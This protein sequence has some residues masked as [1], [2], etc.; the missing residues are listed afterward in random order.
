VT[1]KKAEIK[2]RLQQKWRYAGK[3]S[4]IDCSKQSEKNDYCVH[5]IAL[6]KVKGKQG[7]LSRRQPNLVFQSSVPDKLVKKHS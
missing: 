7:S 3:I 2:S 5:V 6:S 4:R 1:A